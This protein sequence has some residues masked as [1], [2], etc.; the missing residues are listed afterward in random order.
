MQSPIPIHLYC[1]KTQR[2][3]KLCFTGKVDCMSVMAY[4]ILKSDRTKDTNTNNW[5]PRLPEHSTYGYLEHAG[6]CNYGL[7]QLGSVDWEQRYKTN[8][9]R[10]FKNLVQMTDQGVHRHHVEIQDLW[11]KVFALK[12]ALIPLSTISVS[13]QLCCSQ[14]LP[15]LHMYSHRYYINSGIIRPQNCWY[16]GM[17]MHKDFIDPE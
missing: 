12:F 5:T 8:K 7:C 11:I 2:W 14:L 17:Y 1:E 15:Q 6:Y 9:A 4:I 3:I 10:H 13:Q 16:P